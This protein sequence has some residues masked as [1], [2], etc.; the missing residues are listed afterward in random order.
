[1]KIAFY[2]DLTCPWCYIGLK[3]LQIAM[4]QVPEESFT[5]DFLAYQLRDD[6]PDEGID[7]RANLQ[8]FYGLE[9]ALERQLAKVTLIGREVG[10][11]FDFN[12]K[13]VTCPTL[14]GHRLLKYAPPEQRMQLL[15]AMY[16]ALFHRG[17]NLGNARGLAQVGAETGIGSAQTLLG[18]LQS[19]D[20]RQE[21]EEDFARSAR[22]AIITIPYMVMDDLYPVQAVHIAD[23]AL[24][25]IAGMAG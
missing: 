9:E 5:V 23:V 7:Y 13:L 12:R 15:E 2:M 22:T 20:L 1:M 3:R 16:E 21:V 6:L 8:R 10:A 17:V 11:R 25:C 24:S 18:F 4:A 19:E 14:K